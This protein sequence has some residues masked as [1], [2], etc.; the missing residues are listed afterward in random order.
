MNYTETK[1]ATKRIQ[2][3]QKYGFDLDAMINFCVILM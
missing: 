1:L 2:N 3:L